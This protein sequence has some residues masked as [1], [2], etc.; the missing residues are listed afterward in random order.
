MAVRSK[1]LTVSG[2]VA[3]PAG[4]E[5]KVGGAIFV[6]SSGRKSSRVPVVV[7]PET[8]I[9]VARVNLKRESLIVLEQP[10]VRKVPFKEH[11]TCILFT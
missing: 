2:D 4:Y 9:G 10:V 1:E 6:A 5:E 3:S 8:E 11:R 7:V